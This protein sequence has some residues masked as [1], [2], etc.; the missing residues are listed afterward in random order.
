MIVKFIKFN[1]QY[2]FKKTNLFVVNV[3][4]YKIKK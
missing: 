1:P 2:F 4:F 3:D